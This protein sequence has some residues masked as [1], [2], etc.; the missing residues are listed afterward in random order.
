MQFFSIKNGMVQES[1]IDLN[2]K[3]NDSIANM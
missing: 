3:L 1:D 2:R